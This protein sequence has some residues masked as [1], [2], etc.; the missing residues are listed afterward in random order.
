MLKRSSSTHSLL[1]N[2][3]VEL[4]WSRSR[5][6][7]RR[8][9]I[10]SSLR[11]GMNRRRGFCLGSRHVMQWGVIRIF[12]KLI[13]QMVANGR[14]IEAYYYWSLPFLRPQLFPLV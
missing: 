6:R 7:L 13:M 14:F 3:T 11:L 12:K 5:R 2:S 4:T 1:P 10:G 8:R 9:K